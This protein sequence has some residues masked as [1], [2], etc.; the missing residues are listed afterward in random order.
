MKKSNE[1]AG[2]DRIPDYNDAGN[3]NMSECVESRHTNKKNEVLQ[4]N[5]K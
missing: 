1:L 4:T 3:V 2:F 5:K